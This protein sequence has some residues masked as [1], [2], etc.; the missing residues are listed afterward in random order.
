MRL[1][2][3]ILFLFLFSVNS[4]CAVDAGYDNLF[5]KANRLYFNGEFEA[6]VK[7]Y[8]SILKN[9]KSGLLFYSESCGELFYNIG[10]CYFRL[11]EKG[12]AVLNYERA[13]LFM[14]RDADLKYNIDYLQDRIEDDISWKENII[15]DIFGVKFFSRTEL[16]V[17]FCLVNFLFFL[18]LAVRIFFK[19]EWTFYLV[20]IFLIFWI[21]SGIS[22]GIMLKGTT[23]DDR[24]VI[25][26]KEV[27]VLAGPDQEDTL[28]FKLHE[29]TM[30]YHE[31]NESGFSLI[32]LPDGKRGW[33][34]SSAIEG[35]M[36]AT[37]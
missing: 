2:C 25:L 8:E 17:L 3:I 16:A 24:A 6:A 10:N 23:F 33:L 27:N 34:V 15:S 19:A 9:Y 29:G 22:F 35:I 1:F 11:G 13:R 21:V 32:R 36:P 20:N 14:P 4:A 5:F 30:A 37:N 28:L 26:E 12:K 7:T 31:R 18:F